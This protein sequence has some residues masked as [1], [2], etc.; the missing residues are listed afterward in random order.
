ME[1]KE[2]NYEAALTQCLF[3]KASRARLPL[4]GTF[5]L[6]PVCN[7]NCRMC[8]VHLPDAADLIGRE[9][10]ADTWIDIVEPLARRVEDLEKT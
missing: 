1:R 6:S 5:E 3:Q 10:S 7:L 2:V 9:L 4:S 8:Y